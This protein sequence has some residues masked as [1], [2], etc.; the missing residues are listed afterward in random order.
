MEHFD[1][2][3]QIFELDLIFCGKPVQGAEDRCDLL[4]VACVAE[5]TCCGVVYCWSFLSVEDFMP[6]YITLLYSS[7]EVKKAGMIEVRS[8]SAKMGQS[9]LD[10]QR[11]LKSVAHGRC[12]V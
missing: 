7:Q 10:N 12:N 2:K 3:A 9:L 6:K 5:E 8:L 11:W 1:N 4:T